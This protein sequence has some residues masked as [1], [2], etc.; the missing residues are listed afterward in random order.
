MTIKCSF[1]LQAVISACCFAFGTTSYA[2][3]LS[4]NDVQH[5]NPSHLVYCTNIA[6]FS[7]NPQKV[8]IGTN[9][10]VI[11]EQI[12]DK[13]FDWDP[14][15]QQIRPMLAERYTLSPDQRTLTLF[16]RRDVQFHHTPWFT[17]TRHFN[18]DDVVFS[19][20]RMMG[21][22]GELPK[23]NFDADRYGQYHRQQNKVY[24]QNLAQT[25]SPYAENENNDFVKAIADIRAL[26]DDQ[27]QIRLHHNPRS[28]LK[29]L[30]SH[31]A[32]MLSKEYALQLNADENLAQ[33]DLLPVG[34]GVYQLDR[35]TQHHFAQ[36]RPNP[37]YW[38]EKAQTDNIIIDIST[39]SNGRMAK[40]I[41]KE[42]DIAAF[43]EPSQLS[44]RKNG[45]VVAADGANLAY[46]AFN[47]QR[48]IGQNLALRQQIAHAIQRKRLAERLFY[49]IANVAENVLP[50]ALF[51]EA[52]PQSYS[53][54]HVDIDKKPRQSERL[55]LWVIDEKRVYNPHPMK[56]A[57]MIRADL[58]RHGITL[59]IKSVS[60]AFVIQ[61]LHAQNADYDLILSGWL[62]HNLDPVDFLTPLLAC[63]HQNA[64][65]NLANW[66][67]SEFEYW[68]AEARKQ[69]D[70]QNTLL[71]HKIIQH[72]LQEN[73]PLV[74]LVNV[75]RVLVVSDKIENAVINSLGEVNLSQITVNSDN[76]KDEKK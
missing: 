16:L 57:E 63:Q 65:S 30:A 8:D 37:R 52:N 13:L 70:E 46:L 33:I 47:F 1:Y 4:Q 44:A 26:N 42:C 25:A 48:P 20:Q 17:P 19:L 51:P 58:A 2:Q 68:L 11:T 55:V 66:C 64:L 49:G 67:D 34:S 18:A 71:I 73:L 69:P 59:E 7:F 40:F 31:Y 35:F 10:N 43:P 15:T 21:K 72:I 62:A 75:N 41:Q 39:D 3:N 23:L 56:M 53:F 9:V 6:N 45:R 61:Q 60:R 29:L 74:P 28:F 12:Y 32:P 22:V 27:V 50:K 24:H 5:H 36:L 76:L 14:Q 38:R 54:D